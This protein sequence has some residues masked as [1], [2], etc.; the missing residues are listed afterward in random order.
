MPEM[1]GLEAT[2]AIRALEALL[3]ARRAG[4]PYQ[5]VVFDMLM[6]GMDG[7]E[8]AR[9]VRATPGLESLPLVMASSLSERGQAEQARAVGINRR[10]TKPLRQS[11]LLECVRTLLRAPAPPK[12]PQPQ[13]MRT[14]APA[15]PP[16]AVNARLLV[17]E[18]NPVNQKLI[19]AQLAKL[20][21]RPDIVGN[22]REAVE[23]VQRASYDV[24]LM[25][26]RMPEMNGLEATRA[27]R[28]L[29][30]GKRRTQ[31]IA[32]TANALERDRRSCLEAG[33]DDYLA[34]PLHLEDLR[35]ALERALERR[36]PEP[37]IG[38]NEAA[39][40][41]ATANGADVEPANGASDAISLDVLDGLRGDLAVGSSDEFREI[42]DL[43]LTNAE[44]NCAAVRDALARG[45]RHGVEL[46]AHSLKGSSSTMGAARMAAVCASIEELGRNG[47]LDEARG[48]IEQLDAEFS[49]VQ[50]ELARYR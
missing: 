2:R 4:R 30:V 49:R 13:T 41:G 9:R 37:E 39:A 19:T 48:L 27:I 26:C 1:N 7:V 3:A 45:D 46:A 23:A 32:M 29:E 5:L 34:K 8:F 12:P 47:A 24:I 36:T 50:R 28:A 31:I 25:D 38:A 18:D 42:I 43:F 6:P 14:A 16:S 22:G 15:P 33:M 10:L 35:K 17:A 21:Y 44:R 20:G 40:N 11:Q